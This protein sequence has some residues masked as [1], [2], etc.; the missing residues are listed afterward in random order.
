MPATSSNVMTPASVYCSL[1]PFM[2][3][4]AWRM[5]TAISLA[6][7]RSVSSW[8]PACCTLT[9][10]SRPNSAAFSKSLASP[11]GASLALRSASAC[12]SACARAAAR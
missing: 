8:A 7:S 4:C 3:R 1:T 9:V 2:L 6:T 10:R 5:R 12:C 11:S